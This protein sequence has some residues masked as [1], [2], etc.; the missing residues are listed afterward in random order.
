MDRGTIGIIGMLM[1]L[2]GAIMLLGAVPFFIYGGYIGDFNYLNSCLSI[3]SVGI[4]AFGLGA[5][6]WMTNI[7]FLVEG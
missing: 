6:L 2:A 3:V 4:I 1:F 7:D 5:V